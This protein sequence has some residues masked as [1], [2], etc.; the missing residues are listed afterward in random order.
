[1][2]FT[3][4][5][6]LLGQSAVCEPILRALPEWFGIGEATR[7]YILDV[8]TMPTFLATVEERVVGFLTFRQHSPYA[9][10][11]HVMGVHPRAHRRGVGRALMQA[12]EAHLREQGIEFL[13]VKTLSPAH[14]DQNYAK[15]RAFYRAMGFKPLEEFPDLWDEQHPC[16]QMI[17]G[18]WGG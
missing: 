4:Q 14:P 9:A 6:P 1:M 10:E 15:T 8:E 12:L 5:G 18:L 17:K 11:V 3:L 13:Q 7:Q 16:L 2:E